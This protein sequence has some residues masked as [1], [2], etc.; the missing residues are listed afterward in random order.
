[1]KKLLLTSFTTLGL[2]VFSAN[3]AADSSHYPPLNQVSFQ[4]TAD[5]WATTKTAKVIVGVNAALTDTQ[6]GQVHSQIMA[7][8]KK[9]V[10]N[11]EWHIT[12]FNR[13]KS[14]TGLEQLYVQAEARIPEKALVNL[15]AKAKAVSKPGESYKI[16][17]IQFTP[18]LTEINQVRAELRDKIYDEASAELARL[19]KVYPNQKYNLHT[20]S[21]GSQPLPRMGD[22]MMLMANTAK[23]ASAPAAMAVSNKVRVSASVVLASDRSDRSDRRLG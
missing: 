2:L 19:N 11:I 5:Q 23:A 14:Q 12:R 3:A 7:N 13:S 15:R 10:P 9:I 16:A 17:S 22:R 1:M 18:S 6:L 4:L 20:I 21:F 8:L